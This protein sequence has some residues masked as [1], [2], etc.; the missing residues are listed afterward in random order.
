MRGGGGSV[1]A[2]WGRVGGVSLGVVVLLLGAPAIAQERCRRPG[3]LPPR[4]DFVELGLG[5]RA[6]AVQQVQILLQWLGFYG[7]ASDRAAPSDLYDDAL[8]EAVRQ[9]QQQTRL[10][11]TGRLDQRTWQ[12]LLPPADPARSPCP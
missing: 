3:A 11:P 5:D 12:T 6:P 9:F 2:R 10:D 1:I 8:A 7:D 4:Q